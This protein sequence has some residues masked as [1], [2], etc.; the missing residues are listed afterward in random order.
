MIFLKKEK[1]NIQFRF[2][3]MLKKPLGLLLLFQ[4]FL[5][6]GR[7]VSFSGSDGGKEILQSLTAMWASSVQGPDCA[8]KVTRK[9]TSSIGSFYFITV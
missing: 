3:V 4:I 5:L 1:E 7:G 8:R 2:A 6:S 9:G